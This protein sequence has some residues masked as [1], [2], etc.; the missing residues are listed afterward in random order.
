M[1][2][3]CFMMRNVK[4][5]E[6][7]CLEYLEM[8]GYTIWLIFWSHSDSQRQKYISVILLVHPGKIVKLPEIF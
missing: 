2:P 8:I 6:K 5:I 1:F 7:S 3:D 4:F